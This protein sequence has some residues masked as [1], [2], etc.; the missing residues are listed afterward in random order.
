V[1]GV[2][3]AIAGTLVVNPGKT[4]A[5]P[6]FAEPKVVEFFLKPDALGSMIARLRRG[7]PAIAASEP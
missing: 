6:Q 5:V 4:F 7:K 1:T 3:W 2:Y